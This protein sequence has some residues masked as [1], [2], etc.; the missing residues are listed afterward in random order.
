MDDFFFFIIVALLFVLNDGG[1]S[2][3]LSFNEWL[4]FYRLFIMFEIILIIIINSARVN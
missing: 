2:T 1:Y 3:K 4:F